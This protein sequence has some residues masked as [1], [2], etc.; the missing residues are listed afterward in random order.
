MFVKRLVLSA[1]GVFAAFYLVGCG[2]GSKPVGVTV[3]ASASTVDGVTGNTVTLT[4]TVANDKNAAGVSWSVSGGGTVSGSTTSATY[5]P[6]AAGA[7]DVTATVTATSV[8]DST[9]TGQTTIKVPAAPAV[10]TTSASLTGAVGTAYSITLTGSGGIPPYKNWKVASSGSALPTCLTLSSAGVLTT[11]SGTAPTASCA[12]TYGNLIFTYTDSGTPSALTATSAAM[13]ITITAPSITFSPTLP[14]GSVGAAYTGSVAA[15]GALGTT[16]YGLASGALPPDL[17]LNTSTGA[18]TGIPKV[19][20]VGTAHFAI[21]VTDAY[22]D[23]ATSGTLSFTVAAAPAITFG[24]A[25]TVTATFGAAYAS[26]VAATGGAGSLTYSVASGALPPDLGLNAGTGAIAGTPKAAD[27]GTFTFAVKAAD[28]FG[29]SATSGNYSIVVGYPAVTITPAA[30]S[31]PFAVSGQ[32]YSQTLTAAGGS[33]IGFTWTVTGLPASGLSYTANGATLTINGPANATGSVNLTASVTDGAGNTNTGGALAYSIKVYSPVTLPTTIPATLP[34]V[35]TMNLAYS[36]TVTASGGSGNYTWTVTG[37][38]DGLSSTSS[39]GTLTISGTPTAAASLTVNVSVKDTTTGV[40]AG[41]AAYT[42]TVYASVTLPSSNP[43]TLGPA[44]VSTPYSGTIVA[45]GG[46]GN[47]SWTVTGLPSDNLNYSTNGA[48]LTIAGTPGAT[49]T[50]VLFTAKVTD[51]TTNLSSGPYTYTVG[52]YNAISLSASSLPTNATATMPYTGT[53]T[54]SGGSGS[55]YVWTVTGLSDGL[56][57]SS[58]GATL[59]IGGTPTSV[60]TVTITA[61]VK[62]GAGNTAGPSNYTINVYNALTLPTSNPAT[63]GPATI[64]LLYSGTIVAAGGSGNY[65]WTVTGLPSDSLSSSAN[66]GTLTVSGTPGTATTVS[67]TAKV[68]DTTTNFSAGPYPYTVTV[69]NGLTLPSANPA[70]LGSATANSPYTGTI[71]VAGGSGNYSWT[72]TGISDGL[73]SATSGST[74]TISGTP[75]SAATVSF[76]VTVKDTSTNT[77]AGP[78]TYTIAVSGPLS[79]PT[80]NPASL[81][82]GYTQLAYAGSISGSGGSGNLTISVTSALS[83]ANGTMATNV[84]G[85][86]VNVTGTPANPATESFTVQ[87]KDNTANSSISQT[88]TISISTPTAPSLPSP[89]STVPGPA[90]VSQTYNGSLIATGGVGP[91][92]T[93]TVNGATVSGSQTLGPTGLASQFSVSNSGSSSLSISGSP[94]STTGS[95]V[96]FTAQVKDNTTG[97]SSSSQQYTITVNPAGS[98]V[99]GQIFLDNYCYNGNSNLPVTFTVGLYNGST[100]VKSTTTDISGNY[101]FTSISD[102]TYSIKPS[103]AGAASLFYPLSYTGL[104]LSSSGTNNV[105]GKNFGANVG[106]TVSGTVSYSGAQTGQTYLVV[107]NNSCGGNGTGTSITETVLK[108]GGAFTIRGVP[109]G[110]NTI[111]AWMDPLGQSLQNTID[112]TGSVAVTVD[113]NVSS[114]DLTMAD[115][116]FTTPSENPTIQAIIP[117]SQGLFIEFKPSQNSNSL[118]DANQYLVQWSTSPTLGGGTGGGQFAT[119]AGS[120]TFTATGDNGVWVLNNVVLAG[121]GFSFTSG[122]TYYFQARSFNTL[123]TANPHP[124]GWCNYTATGCGGITGFTGVTIGTPDCTGCTPVSSSVTIPAA[125]TI[126]AGAP[127]YLGMIQLSGAGGNPIGIYVTEITNPVNGVNNF[128]QPINVPSGSNY[129]VFGMLDQNKTGGF[130]AGTITNVR[131]E[132]PASDYLTI[133]ASTNTQNVAGVSLP[134]ANSVATVSTQFSTSSCQGCGSTSTS[135]QLNFEVRESNKL[136]VAVTLTSG[137]N[138]INTSGTVAIDMANNCNGCGGTDLQYYVTLPGGTPKVGDTYDFT[139]T[140]LNPDGTTSQDTG[141]TVT[142]AVTGWNGGS[143]VVDA[144]DAPSALAPNDNTSTSTTPTFTWTDSSS[145]T[146]SDFNY[147]FYLSDQTTC[148]GNCTIWQIPGNNSKSN[149]FSSSITSIVWLTDPTN[150]NPANPPSVLSLTSGDVYN[151]SIQ[152]QDSNRNSAQTSV[153]YQP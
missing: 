83:P 14:Q 15:T 47:Y 85:T 58:S 70:T 89:S 40:T 5:T 104:A 56:T 134:S 102:G 41:P 130:G 19:A 28:T 113:A 78:V 11:A 65:S 82:A 135:Y 18:V 133:P 32:S 45:A 81:P 129:I 42:I 131:N 115:P 98:Q 16:T 79:L 60:A 148:S 125:I 8:A 152:V 107:Q 22:G 57:S 59:T 46:S 24:S 124:T 117:N 120:H 149:G 141:T 99:S 29:D 30:G 87:L 114:A 1:L 44:L 2:G 9:K 48:T 68:T 128:P 132:I 100:L 93:W 136:P 69:Y 91:T 10:S 118:E 52:I 55:G 151:W 139:V 53:I 50:T 126:N 21:S 34:S 108:A 92:Y 77:T 109:P 144:S 76:N 140:Y 145:S 84:S 116:T 121:S 37:L 63:L 39:G 67:F 23:T 66:G 123:D 143:T 106:F 26:G 122:Q 90:T 103:I 27:I 7:A 3:T 31:L 51:T 12:G 86:T 72:V 127:L 35:G 25:P 95:P 73:V 138:L 54:A 150:P 75:T 153:W 64:N 71:V 101:S 110:D 6:P 36:G 43:S 20:D 112:P 17:S 88:Y 61:S 38:S 97:L 146:G 13:S 33:G 74:L 119:I 96:T 94:T 137:P 111:S 142:G 4:A 147:S 62:D 80:P 49:P 105:Q